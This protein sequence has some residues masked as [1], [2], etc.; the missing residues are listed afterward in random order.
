MRKQKAMDIPFSFGRIVKDIDYTDRVEDAQHLLRNFA[1]L[2]NT[3]I[4]SP[5]RWGKSSLVNRTLEL[6]RQMNEDY[7]VIKMVLPQF[8]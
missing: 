5:R 8:S 3:T 6:L 1:A 2:T 4:I 7:I